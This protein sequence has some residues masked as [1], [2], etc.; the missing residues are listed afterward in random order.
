MI[1]RLENQEYKVL[2]ERG[3]EKVMGEIQMDFVKDWQEEIL[4]DIKK[5]E[6]KSQMT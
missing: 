2:K 5:K 3:N 1:K 6:Y 4:K